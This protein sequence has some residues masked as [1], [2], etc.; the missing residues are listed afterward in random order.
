MTIE[1]TILISVLS[2]SAAIFFGIKSQKRADVNDIEERT[3]QNTEVKVKLDEALV[4]LKSMQDELKSLI[5]R[6]TADEKKTDM[7][8]V[9]VDSIEKRLDKLEKGGNG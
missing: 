2:V 3:R 1:I 5:D 7:L 6:V 9:K 8:A 4:L